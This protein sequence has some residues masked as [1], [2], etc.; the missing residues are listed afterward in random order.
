[1]PFKNKTLPT[2][3]EVHILLFVELQVRQLEEQVEQAPLLRKLF[4]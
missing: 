4:G 2:G 1:V 3:H